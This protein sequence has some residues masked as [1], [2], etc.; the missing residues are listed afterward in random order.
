MRH[1]KQKI[2]KAKYDYTAPKF[3]ALIGELAKCRLSNQQIADRLG[4]TVQA[5][6]KYAKLNP[7]IGEILANIR[8]RI[9]EPLRDIDIPDEELFSWMLD[10]CVNHPEDA[11]CF[12]LTKRRVALWAKKSRKIKRVL[13]TSK[14]WAILQKR[15]NGDKWI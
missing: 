11:K 5:F 4:I 6:R 13:K 12:G 15:D 8:F 3:I 2:M 1:S 7:F 10:I 9:K 14:S